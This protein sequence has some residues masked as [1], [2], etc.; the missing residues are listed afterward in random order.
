MNIV[1]TLAIASVLSLGWMTAS[2]AE[3]LGTIPNGAINDYLGSGVELEGWYGANFALTGTVTLDFDFIGWEAGYRNTFDINTGSGWTT[4]F[5]TETASLGGDS[6]LQEKFGTLADPLKS[7][8]GHSFSAGTVA[9]RFTSAGIGSVTNGSN[10]DDSGGGAP[11]NF[12]LSFLL[13]GTTQDSCTIVSGSCSDGSNPGSSKFLLLYDDS[14]AGHDDNHD[15]MVVAVTVG[16]GG[17]NCEFCES[18][19][20][21]GSL[22][23]LGVGLLGLG[24]HRRVRNAR[25][26]K[27]MS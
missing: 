1:R 24:F 21:P 20:E 16:G 6:S 13:G 12:F 19:P 25:K 9:F 2:Q 26:S 17:P 18:I 23:L 4:I 22:V 14:G 27:K 11:I 5:D 15:D 10:A 7:S 8:D 3:T